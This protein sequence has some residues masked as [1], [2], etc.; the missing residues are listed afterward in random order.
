[1]KREMI[2]ALK[3]LRPVNRA[4]ICNAI[5]LITAAPCHFMI[6]IA[7][8]DCHFRRLRITSRRA[9]F[10]FEGNC[11]K[12][13][14]VVFLLLARNREENKHRD[15]FLII[16]VCCRLMWLKLRFLSFVSV[17]DHLTLTTW[18]NREINFIRKRK[19]RILDKSQHG[20]G[21]GRWNMM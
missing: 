12:F 8:G 20:S 2:D 16:A 6:I 18:R 7:L 11:A 5:A 1:M 14:N 9:A 21:P 10:V 4:N 15:F 13:I 3:A 19:E 17:A